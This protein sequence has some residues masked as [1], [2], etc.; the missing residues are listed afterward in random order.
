VPPFNISK[1]F[2]VLPRIVQY[3]PQ[4]LEVTL[5][6]TLIGLILG[7]L[8]AYLLNQPK[9]S[10]GYLFIKTYN[11]IIR[12]TPELIL[13]L[14]V[15]YGLP[16]LLQVVF[17]VNINNIDKGIFAIIALSLLFSA[18]M[19]I[20]FKSAYSTVPI[21]QSEAALSIGLSPLQV[22]RK[23][24]G[25]QALRIAV[26]NIVNNMLVLLK[27]GSLTYLIGYIDIMGEA[28]QII[29]NN[30]GKFSLETYLAVALIYWVIAVVIDTIG[31]LIEKLWNPN[32]RGV[33]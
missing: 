28:Q 20:V 27:L 1:V 26:P 32:N 6:V 13:I 17:L 8:F 25:L 18:N 31:K 2:E 22:L 24:T 5:W 4:T 30:F 11:H 10:L 19:S 14:L 3:L 12:S 15:F 29:A 7:L 9:N 33:K 16:Q 21:G 23:V